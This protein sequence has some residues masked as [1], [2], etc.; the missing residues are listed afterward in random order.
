MHDASG[1]VQQSAGRSIRTAR[2][3]QVHTLAGSVTQPVGGTPGERLRARLRHRR[4][5]R[6]PQPT[7][8]PAAERRQFQGP[9]GQ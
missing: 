9:L 4:T 7:H 8:D 6:H 2:T 3:D 1:F 5:A